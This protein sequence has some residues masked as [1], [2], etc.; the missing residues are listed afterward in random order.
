M[1]KW[2]IGLTVI[3]VLGITGM[4]A[5]NS[6]SHCQ[7]PCGI[8]G[9]DLRFSL[10]AEHITTIEKAMNQIEE[11]SA[12]SDKNYNQIVR[13][14]TNKDEHA[15]KFTEIVTYYFMAQRVKPVESSDKE[16]YKKYSEQ[17]VMLHKMI[18]NAMKCKQTTDKQYVHELEHLVEDFHKSYTSGK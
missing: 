11:L 12:K 5:T 8:Y 14:V 1:K 15:S 13:W 16:A 10:L 7:I 4:Y 3:A 9:D 18:V 6:F 17:V 2:I